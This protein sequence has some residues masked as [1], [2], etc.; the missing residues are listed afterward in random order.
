MP[1]DDPDY[2]QRLAEIFR[3]K[4]RHLEEARRRE[5]A[6]AKA[7]RAH[8]E[9]FREIVTQCALPVFEALG[10]ELEAYGLEHRVKR[11]GLLEGDSYEDRQHATFEFRFVEETGASGPLLGR[12]FLRIATDME[13]MAFEVHTEIAGGPDTPFARSSSSTRTVELNQLDRA[14]F[15]DAVLDLIEQAVEST[16]R[17]PSA[18]AGQ[19]SESAKASTTGT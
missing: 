11:E 13:S 3:A 9:I 10:E 5:E 16:Y 6:T 17:E 1:H 19:E 15:Q 2:R 14:F 4:E 7:R 18:A 8:A 12:A